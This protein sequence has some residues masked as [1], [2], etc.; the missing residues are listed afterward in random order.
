MRKISYSGPRPVISQYGIEFKEGKEDKY[1]YLMISIQILKAIDKNF[2]ESKHY[3]YDLSSKK[4]AD[5]E[6]LNTMISYE[7]TLAQSVENEAQNYE[8]KI[9]EEIEYIKNLHTIGEIERDV[10]VNNL[11]LMKEYRIQRAINKIFY[12]HSIYEIV[13]IIKR[14][15]IKEIDTPFYEKYWHVLKSIEGTINGEKNSLRANIEVI[16]IDGAM[17]T[18]LII[19]GQS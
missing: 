11:E 4:I 15:K 18:K 3:S 1:V 14:E 16:N 7:P 6:I 12:I 5:E 2:K 17:K 8:K 19:S 9:E 10:W 13:E